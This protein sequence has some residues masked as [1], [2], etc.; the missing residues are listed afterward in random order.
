MNQ[1]RQLAA[2][3]AKII[4]VKPK[5]HKRCK[6]KY[7]ERDL[8]GRIHDVTCVDENTLLID[9]TGYPMI[10]TNHIYYHC[11]WNDLDMVV[12]HKSGKNYKTNSEKEQE[13]IAIAIKFCMDKKRYLTDSDMFSDEDW[14]R[15]DLCLANQI[16]VYD[17]DD[18]WK[19]IGD[20]LN[21]RYHADVTR[22][23]IKRGQ[24]YY[25]LLDAR[26]DN[27]WEMTLIDS[28][29]SASHTISFVKR[30]KDEVE[31]EDESH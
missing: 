24:T 4:K 31:K 21:V 2:M 28:L 11:V 14:P 5:V 18:V 12:H 7:Y 23:I 1:S 16:L 17:K 26:T 15:N 25:D 8:R 20:E 10:L 6:M 30:E 22:L 19:D 29:N 9:L 3:M 27:N 13:R